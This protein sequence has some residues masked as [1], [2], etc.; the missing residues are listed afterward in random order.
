M[1]DESCTSTDPAT[2]DDPA[3]RIEVP[4]DLEAVDGVRTQVV[5]LAA[6]WGFS[7]L[8]DL[9]VVTS[10]LVTNA[11]VHARSASV[12]EIR[13]VLGDCVEVAVSDAD[14]EPPVKRIP[15]EQHTRG[16]GLHI[17]DALCE[18]WGVRQAPAGKTVWARLG[19][20]PT[21]A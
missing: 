11:I 8:E 18:A 2:D 14:P 7:E 1:A 10:E 4:V 6:S 3:L 12:V 19:P 9:E 13:L 21:D 16:L 17:V 15:Y 20:L 5:D